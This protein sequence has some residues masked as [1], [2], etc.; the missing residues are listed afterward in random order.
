MLLRQ[1]VARLA[2]LRACVHVICH[3]T[4]HKSTR[5]APCLPHLQGN[6]VALL[7]SV[8]SAAHAAG[9]T[10][11]DYTMRLHGHHTMR[12]QSGVICQHQLACMRPKHS[13]ETALHART[14]AAQATTRQHASKLRKSQPQ[15][16][17]WHRA[18]S[19]APT[20]PT[21]HSPNP[22]LPSDIPLADAHD[23]RRQV[24]HAC[25]AVATKFIKHC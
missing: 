1:R 2:G 19:S 23:V 17:V 16:V 20:P 3:H 4:D 7:H 5:A 18:P 15:L 10:Q 25:H 11:C 22:R 21:P 13:A 6:S 8:Q 9:T 14:A 12:L 24:A